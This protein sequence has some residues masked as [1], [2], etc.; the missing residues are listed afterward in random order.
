M[1]SARIP[2]YDDSDEDADPNDEL[3]TRKKK[4]LRDAKAASRSK[5]YENPSTSL[6]YSRMVKVVIFGTFW[7]LAMT[8]INFGP[9]SQVLESVAREHKDS[10][11]RPFSQDI[12]AL[13]NDEIKHTNSATSPAEPSKPSESSI[14]EAVFFKVVLAQDTPTLLEFVASKNTNLSSSVLKFIDIQS[15]ARAAHSESLV[16]DLMKVVRRPDYEVMHP[17]INE[18]LRK[19]TYDLTDT[20]AQMIQNEVQLAVSQT[21]MFV[22]DSVHLLLLVPFLQSSLE[23]LFGLGSYQILVIADSG[24]NSAFRAPL[25]NNF[26]NLF[27]H[28]IDEHRIDTLCLDRRQSSTA[29]AR[30]ACKFT[31]YINDSVEWAEGHDTIPCSI[32][33]SRVLERAAFW[34]ALF[35]ALARQRHV[36]VLQA[37]V[38]HDH[39]ENEDGLA[40]PGRDS[41]VGHVDFK[42]DT[43]FAPSNGVPRVQIDGAS[44]SHVAVWRRSVLVHRR[45]VEDVVELISNAQSLLGS[46]V[47]SQDDL[48][49]GVPSCPTIE[50]WPDAGTCWPKARSGDPD[51]SKSF[52]KGRSN[53]AVLA[54]LPRLLIAGVQKAGTAEMGAWLDENPNFRR[55]DGGLETHFFDCTNRGQGSDRPPCLHYRDKRMQEAGNAVVEERDESSA[56]NAFAWREV[57]KESRAWYLY[58][59]L[60]HLNYKQALKRRIIFDKSPAYFDLA[61]PMDVMRLTPSVKIVFILRDPVERF[62]SSYFHMCIRYLAAGDSKC[63]E[64]KLQKALPRAMNR[65]AGYLYRALRVGHY[66][67]HLS[68]WRESFPDEQMLV[69]FAERFREMPSEA[70]RT[71][72][73]FVAKPIGLQLSSGV[74]A[75]PFK[76]HEYHP[77]LAD[78]GF[79]VVNN[80]SKA[81]HPSHH[82]EMLLDTRLK[83]KSYYQSW[84]DRLRRL[85]LS[86]NIPIQVTGSKMKPSNTLT[87]SEFPAWLQN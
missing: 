49:N 31:N 17:S 72:E 35:P 29:W 37:E 51:G 32:L 34:A 56:A 52:R 10:I 79:W 63:S 22:L 60:G 41:L 47:L 55:Q 61:N 15:A 11:A 36:Q 3:L 69:I 42:M 64:A 48:A 8:F 81:F 84:N 71:V 26:E 25:T 45:L 68:K 57:S 38:S 85:F 20:I 14:T 30:P 54:C 40:P 70:L 13:R 6:C 46:V 74:V 62:H 7:M 9:S 4:V 78:N 1:R 12:A 82:S 43:L 73:D 66:S 53:V 28:L 5:D 16:R 86:A 77:I 21:P 44:S 2:A 76:P 24:I 59:T 39:Q 83:L 58:A 27:P 18:S 87:V 80:R 50:R 23:N 33:E 67:E 75:S 19:K 65:H